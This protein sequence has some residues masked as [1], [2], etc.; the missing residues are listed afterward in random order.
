M[1]QVA[2]YGRGKDPDMNPETVDS[3]FAKLQQ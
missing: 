3:E 2:C 1:S